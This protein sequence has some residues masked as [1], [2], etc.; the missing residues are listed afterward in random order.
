MSLNSLNAKPKKTE[1]YPRQ[2]FSTW[3][4]LH[5]AVSNGDYNKL[6]LMIDKDKRKLELKEHPELNEDQDLPPF[7]LDVDVRVPR[8]KQIM[9]TRPCILLHDWGS[10]TSPWHYSPTRLKSMLSTRTNRH[11]CESPSSTTSRIWRL[12]FVRTVGLKKLV[13]ALFFKSRYNAL[14]YEL[15]RYNGRKQYPSHGHEHYSFSYSYLLQ[16]RE[17]FHF[18]LYFEAQFLFFI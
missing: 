15:R 2:K 11:P 12:C 9:G 16:W 1:S 10:S 5:K 17:C 6:L 18:T 13:S 4:P 7:F 14:I 8:G 3:T